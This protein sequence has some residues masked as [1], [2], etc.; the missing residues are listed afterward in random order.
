MPDRPPDSLSV[1]SPVRKGAEWSWRFLA[2]TGALVVIGYLVI[3]LKVIVVPVVIAALLA[4]LLAPVVRVLR[5][6][7]RLPGGWQRS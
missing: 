6:R 1:P 7:A 3:T 5:D 4:A 2:I